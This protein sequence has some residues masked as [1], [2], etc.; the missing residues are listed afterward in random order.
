MDDGIAGGMEIEEVV[1]DARDA[2]GPFAAEDNALQ[3]NSNWFETTEESKRRV[4]TFGTAFSV[5]DKIIRA[6]RSAELKHY[7]GQ[8]KGIFI[9]KKR[10]GRK[11]SL[12]CKDPAC[13]Y[14]LYAKRKP[15]SGEVATITICETTH[16]C[17]NAVNLNIAMNAANAGGGDADAAAKLKKRERAGKSYFDASMHHTDEALRG[18]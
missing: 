8:P 12:R 17:Q 7:P 9:L 4:G 3:N 5:Y 16:S 15:D 18:T 2:R 6:A 10:E 14:N 13:T 1:L 11:L